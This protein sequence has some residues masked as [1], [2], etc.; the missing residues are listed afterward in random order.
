MLLALFHVIKYVL[1]DNIL[2]AVKYPSIRMDH[3]SLT[4][5]RQLDYFQLFFYSYEQCNLSFH[6]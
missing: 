4:I 2:I 5:I 6:S 1:Q 3:N